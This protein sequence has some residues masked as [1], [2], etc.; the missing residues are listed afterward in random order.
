MKISRDE[1]RKGVIESLHRVLGKQ[2]VS[3][4]DD[5]TNPIGDFGLKSED[6]VDYACA[7]S[8]Q[9]RYI[10]PHNVNPFVDDSGR[11]ARRVGEIVDLMYGLL[12]NQEAER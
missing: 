12:A 7:L 6:G 1:I 4:I 3:H 2:D 9:L 5:T 8:E 10:I 11:R